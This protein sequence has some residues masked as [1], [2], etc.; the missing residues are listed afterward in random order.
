MK[1]AD[2]LAPWIV[3]APDRNAKI[4]ALEVGCQFVNAAL[5]RFKIDEDLC[6]DINYELNNHIAEFDRSKVD[7]LYSRLKTSFE[8]VHRRLKE[9]EVARDKAV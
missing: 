9:L 8:R 7:F 5:Q 6:E 3:N 1:V 2:D 4:L